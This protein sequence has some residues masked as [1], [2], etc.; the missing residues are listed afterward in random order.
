AS[1]PDRKPLASKAASTHLE[2]PAP[3]PRPAASRDPHSLAPSA[4]APG[5]R[6]PGWATPCQ[7]CHVPRAD[8]AT[9]RRA[10]DAPGADAAT[11]RRVLRL[12]GSASDAGTSASVTAVRDRFVRTGD[13]RVDLLH[14]QNRIPPPAHRACRSDH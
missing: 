11:W 9:W 6:V 1:K 13:C 4:A 7:S 2:D 5:P 10:P 12:A 3:S 8:A 14:L